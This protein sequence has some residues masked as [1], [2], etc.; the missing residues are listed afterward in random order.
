MVEVGRSLTTMKSSPHAGLWMISMFWLTARPWPPGRMMLRMFSPPLREVRSVSE[1]AL[2][3]RAAMRPVVG[4]MSK[5][6]QRLPV[7]PSGG[8]KMYSG[9]IGSDGLPKSGP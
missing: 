7:A 4:W 5:S 6:R 2:L 1:T 3:P 8:K 9:A